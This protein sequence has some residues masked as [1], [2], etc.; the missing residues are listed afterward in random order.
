MD[1]E[2]IDSWK[3]SKQLFLDQLQRNQEEL[4]TKPPPHW[5]TFI[6]FVNKYINDMK[7]GHLNM[8]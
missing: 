1:Q 2:H 8:N 3:S 6:D 4:K 5:R 7:E